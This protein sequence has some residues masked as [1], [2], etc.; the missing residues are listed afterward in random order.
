MDKEIIQLLKKTEL[1]DRNHSKLSIHH[2]PHLPSYWELTF[3]ITVGVH[4]M[5]CKSNF[6]SFPGSIHYKIYKGNQGDYELTR[7]LYSFLSPNLK[8]TKLEQYNAGETLS[9]STLTGARNSPSWKHSP[10]VP[11]LF[12]ESQTSPPTYWEGRFLTYKCSGL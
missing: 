9:P 4:R 5:V 6:V 3:G 2:L 10:W 1:M 12:R 11:F 7:Q 8:S